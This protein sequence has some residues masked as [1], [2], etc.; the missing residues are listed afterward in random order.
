MGFPTNDDQWEEKQLDEVTD[1]G[2][3][4]WELKFDGGWC[5]GAPNGPITPKPGMTIRLYGKGTG[6]TIRGIFID[7]HEF[8]YRTVPEEKQSHADW[9]AN[10]E[11]EDQQRLEAEIADR[12]AKWAALPE[13]Y[14]QRMARFAKNNATWRRDYEEYELFVCEQAHL[15]ATALKTR[16]AIAKF[17][18]MDEGEAMR[19]VPGLDGG[20]SGNTLG[21]ACQLAA[22]ELDF[23]E[24]VVRTHGAISPLVGSKKHGDQSDEEKVAKAVMDGE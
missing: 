13:V 22:Y 7:G 2:E 19:L 4:G 9:V 8:R 16:A 15:I 17:H 11:C 6:Y 23:P 24:G 18:K 10:K 12:D 21:A 3:N 20:H 14:Q 5:L 1:W